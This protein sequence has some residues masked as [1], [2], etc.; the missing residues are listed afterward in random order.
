MRYER[1][2]QDL[3]SSSIG[4]NEDASIDKTIGTICWMKKS[5]SKSS[6]RKNRKLD[7]LSW[8]DFFEIGGS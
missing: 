5:L 7:K 6:K 8:V 3:I 4:C 1:K 2:Q